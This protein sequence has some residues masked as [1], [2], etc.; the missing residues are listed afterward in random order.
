MASDD[1]Q[2]RLGTGMDHMIVVVFVCL[3]EL[4]DALK[5]PIITHAKT[6]ISK[7]NS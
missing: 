4:R 2:G 3:L 7:L 1:I 5:K 6:L